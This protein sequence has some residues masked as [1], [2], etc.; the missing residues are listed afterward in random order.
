M[1]QCACNSEIETQFLCMKHNLYLCG[2]CLK[3]RDPELY[4]KFRSACPIWFLE[5][6]GGK[7]LLDED[8]AAAEKMQTRKVSFVPNPILKI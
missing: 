8:T 2:E 3:C 5:K 1:G 4:C 7:E 6:K